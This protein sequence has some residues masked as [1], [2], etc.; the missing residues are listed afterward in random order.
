MY[1]EESENQEGEPP[2]G[3]QPSQKSRG[4]WKHFKSPGIG[5]PLW[6]IHL[7]VQAQK[8]W[9]IQRTSTEERPGG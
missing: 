7:T 4:R 2:S 1:I 9:V 8:K 6:G 5:D 3:P